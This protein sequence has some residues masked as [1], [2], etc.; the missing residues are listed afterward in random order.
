MNRFAQL[1]VAAI[2]SIA[3]MFLA[4]GTSAAPEPRIDR[5]AVVLGAQA[6]GRALAVSCGHPAQ[7]RLIRFED[8]SALLRCGDR[9]LVRISVPG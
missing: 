4:T 7:L 9:I 6:G 8:G 3:L 2:A 5:A 1:L